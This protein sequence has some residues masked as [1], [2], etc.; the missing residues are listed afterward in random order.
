MP[1]LSTF[2]HHDERKDRK[3][4][5]GRGKLSDDHLHAVGCDLKEA[6]PANSATPNPGP[7]AILIGVQL[8]GVSQAELTE[9]LDELARLAKTLGLRPIGR[10]TQ[11]RSGTG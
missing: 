3:S 1:L 5:R 6:M 11:H 2:T 7:A 10:L 8:P 9:S 4:T